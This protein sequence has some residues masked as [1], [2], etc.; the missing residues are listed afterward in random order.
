MRRGPTAV[1][2]ALTVLGL[3]AA[4]GAL[5]A[6]RAPMPRVTI[7]LEGATLRLQRTP[8]GRGEVY[9][10]GV[11]RETPLGR[12]PVG[13]FYTGPDPRDREFYLPARHEPAFHRGL[14][15]LRIDLPLGG[16][17][18][19]RERPFG[20]HGPVTPTL[21]WGTVSAGCVR[22]RDQDLRRLYATAVRH[23][24][25]PFHF[26]RELDRVAGRPVEV[27]RA[28]HAP[29]TCPEA[30]FGLRRLRRVAID[31]DVHDRICGGVDH[32]YALELRG[33]DRL[34]VQ[35]RH[36]GGL[37]VELYGIRAITTVAAGRF[38]L[39]HDVPL[40]HSNRGDRY[41]RVVADRGGKAVPYTLR[42]SMR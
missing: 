41:L 31:A 10:V 33:G 32:W 19:I 35:L 37:A 36:D 30:A 12:G 20:I 11:G 15:F 38:G 14:P 27:D 29:A 13:T 17:Q 16:K 22:M 23:P 26:I 5:L 7:S 3:G 28:R 40:A 34:A 25:M 1:A 18:G 6:A 24:R 2:A 42:L 9:P 8:R 4:G 21:I 39:E